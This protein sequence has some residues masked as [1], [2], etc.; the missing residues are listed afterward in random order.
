MTEGAAD[1]RRENDRQAGAEGDMGKVFLGETYKRE[2]E[3]EQGDKDDAAAD[4]EQ[5]GQKTGEGAQGEKQ[6][7]NVGCDAWHRLE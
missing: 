2:S 6:K 1:C 5:T 3:K 7:E 4:A